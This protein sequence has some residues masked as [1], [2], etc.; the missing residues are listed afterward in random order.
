MSAG[1]K[2]GWGDL[3][4]ALGRRKS[5]AMFLLGFASGLPYVLITGTLNAWF[6]EEKVSVATIGVS[7]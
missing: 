5:G 6:T 4:K 2:Y 3:V 7:R 1:K